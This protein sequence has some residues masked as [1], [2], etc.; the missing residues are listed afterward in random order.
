MLGSMPSL[1]ESLFAV[2]VIAGVAP[3]LTAVLPGPSIPQVVFLLL[4][5][6]LIGPEVLDFADPDQIEVLSQLGLGFLFL[7]A[8]YELEIALFRQIPG[9]IAI[10]AWFITALLATALVLLAQRFETIDGD[11]EVMIAL[12][13]TALGTLLPI[14]R[15]NGTLG[16]CVGTL[17]VRRG[18][19][20]GILPDRRDGPA[21]QF[22]RGDRR[23]HR[24]V[25]D[26]DRGVPR[27]EGPATGPAP[28]PL[29]TTGPAG[30]RHRSDHAAVDCDPA[31]VPAVPRRGLRTG[32][33]AGGIPGRRGTQAVGTR[34]HEGP[35]TQ[36]RGSQLGTVR[37]GVLHQLGYDP[38]HRLDPGGP[39]EARDVRSAAASGA[40]SFLPST[41]IGKS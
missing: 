14:L 38:G 10:R 5:G 34:Q 30:A 9:K 28:G 32:H 22:D 3:I 4:G 26:G 19:C 7:L 29:G 11:I 35:G 36:T 12:T 27:P 15:D 31:R 37:A 21:A 13:T 24:A 25:R 8:G 18:R 20:R 1:L 6:I 23:H 16:H 17:R 40:W 39:L 2:A 41:C 33:R